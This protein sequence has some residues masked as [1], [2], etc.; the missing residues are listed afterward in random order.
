MVEKFLDFSPALNINVETLKFCFLRVSERVFIYKGATLLSEM[1][2]T[3]LDE[4]IFRI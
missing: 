3:F 2:N 1:I 4:E